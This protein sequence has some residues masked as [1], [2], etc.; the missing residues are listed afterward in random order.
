M[1]QVVQSS[2]TMTH[3]FVVDKY[4]KLK[5]NRGTWETH[6]EEIAKYVLPM[7]DEIYGSFN[8]KGEKKGNTLFDA[9]GIRSNEQLASALHGMLTNPATQWFAFG[10][11]NHE[12]DGK[13]ENA[14]WLQ[15]TAKKILFVM[16]NSNFQ[17]EIH[18][19]YLDLCG[20]GTSHL[21]IEEDEKE[22]ARFTSRPIYEA[23]ISENYLGVID[24]VYYKYKITCE[25]LV[26]QFPDTLPEAIKALRHQEPLKEYTII[27]AIEPSS[28]LPE[29]VRHKM[30]DFTS[31]HVLEEGCLL[32][33]KGGFEENPCIISRFS[34]LSGEMF[35]RSPAM[36]GLPDIKTSNQMMKTWL[37]GA[38]LAVNPALQAPDE[39]VLMPIR[40]TPGAINYYRADSKDRIEPINMGVNPQ[41]GTQVI[42]LLHQNIKSAFYIDQLHLV[43]SDRMTATEV[44]Q[45]RDEQLRS[46]SPILGRLQ[47]E[48]LAPIVMRIFGIMMRKGL[49]DAIPQ[50]LMTAKLEVK[51]VSQIARAQESV[52]GDAFMRA[53]QAVAGIGQA[54]QSP[55]VF[56]VIDMDGAV[57]FLFRSYGSPLNL[58]KKD[59]DVKAI[60]QQRQQAQQQAQQAEMDQ[61]NSQS[62][63]NMSQA[64]PGA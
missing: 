16:N 54:Q 39:G 23:V 51:F 7:K 10:S 19:C 20:F 2:S 60:R 55:E 32:L 4:Q 34:K 40:I 1:L 35:G 8:T 59:Q 64:Q 46:M 37:E 48:L 12:V 57:K 44:M 61:M 42:E 52:E 58:L 45:R 9:I 41:V 62:M 31:M 43:E 28:R 21:R 27:H 30:L 22:V 5:V 6:W 15:N 14:K 36:K 24:T 49:I 38:Q 11:G 3:K 63:K 17:S 29:N 26:E 50:E 33:K 53:F 47:Y 56:D 25:A 13:L 18:E